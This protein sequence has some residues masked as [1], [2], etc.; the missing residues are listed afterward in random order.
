MSDRESGGVFADKEA[1]REMPGLAVDGEGMKSILESVPE[2][3]SG[4]ES[5]EMANLRDSFFSQLPD[6]C[7][8][9]SVRTAWQVLWLKAVAFLS[10][11]QMNQ[12]GKAFLYA[13]RGHEHQKR[14]SGEPYILHTVSVAAI[15][16]E[17]QI[18]L[19]TLCASL[20]HDLIE[21]TDITIPELSAAFGEEIVTL[22]DGVTKLGKLPFMSVEGYQAENLRK[23]FIVM[24]RDI[25][26]V[27]IKLADR[28]H[29]MR[30]LAILRRDKQERI[31]KETLEIFAPL[32]HRLGI[33]QMKRDLEDLA[34]KYLSPELYNEIR[35]K[36]RRKLPEREEVIRKGIGVLEARLAKE[37]IPCKLKGRTKHFYSIYE[38]MERKKLSIDELYDILAIRVLVDDIPACYA[39][40]G[41]VHSLWAPIPLQFDDYIA[42]PKNNM[43]Q[44]LHTTVMAFGAPMEV[45]IR[46]K[47]MNR[48][49]EY[50]I[51][52]HWR[53]KSGGAGDS[54][55]EKLTW[56]RQALEG[57]PEGHDPEEFLELL[58]S[59]VLASEV[60]GFTPKGKAVVLPK[61]ATTIDFAYAVHTEVGNRC[62]GAMVNNRIVP[63]S[64]EIQSGDIVKIITSPQGAPSRD[65][66]KIA[67]STKTRSKIRTYF[68]QAEKTDREEKTAR[69][70][71]AL[72]REL[73]KRG[74]AADDPE[75][76][77]PSL[78]K[79]ARD[80]GLAGKEDLLI[81]IGSGS[82]G[83]STVAQKLALAHLQQ[84]HPDDLASLLKQQSVLSKKS[85]LDVIVEGFEGV[86]VVLASCCEPV[87]GDTIVGYSTRNRG[88]TVHRI[89]CPNILNAQMGRVI[90]VQWSAAQGSGKFYTARIK[91]E[92]VD[93][94]DL[95]RD[96]AH[97][98]GQANGSIQGM[99][100]SIVDNSLVR[101]K[102]EL[103]VRNLEHLYEI[104]GKVNGVR[105]IIEVSRA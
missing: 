15:L 6:E 9:E 58:K 52:A 27:L 57:D 18:D 67:K 93:R 87:P 85:D 100:V 19:A 95:V 69:G 96:V 90:N 59:D 60:Y 91:A 51:A 4:S 10:S 62:V 38:K 105:G 8:T 36:V 24:A 44:S 16:A 42:N 21:D 68:R 71:E 94:G 46:T 86:Q 104:T 48:L 56:V 33:Y 34:F 22:V 75:E 35:R 32:A 47:E 81:A 79:V 11:S 12:L 102:I 3:S 50:G 99:K 89:D 83:P 101:I 70:W 23:M 66:M 84:R 28:L 31:A 37:G 7:K 72:D 45:Q 74:L 54:L 53:Y 43:Y 49:A 103:R 61:G 1:G 97:V 63:L 73:K 41:I 80:L 55:D 17:M 98:I 76:F 39:V 26:V 25:R 78:N 2:L 92:A 65:W 30:T 88:I 13:G 40:L 29:N 82:A 5:K 77:S 64:T 20:L 14:S